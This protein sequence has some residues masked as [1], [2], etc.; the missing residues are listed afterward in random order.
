MDAMK[1]GSWWWCEDDSLKGGC[2]VEKRSGGGNQREGG[3]IKPADWS[4]GS[5]H[6]PQKTEEAPKIKIHSSQSLI[7]KL[8]RRPKLRLLKQKKRCRF[9]ESTLIS[10][11]LFIMPQYSASRGSIPCVRYL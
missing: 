4:E 6:S 11:F 10:K 7:P 2:H 5:G 3:A 8:K 1:M 9:F